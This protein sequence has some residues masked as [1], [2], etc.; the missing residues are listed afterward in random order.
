M[1][2]K[3]ILGRGNSKYKG[4]KG[5]ERDTKKSVAWSTAGDEKRDSDEAGEKIVGQI[6]RGLVGCRRSL[7]LFSIDSNS[8]ENLP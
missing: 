4:S 3:L 2:D 1:G 7:E 6:I 5:S 8:L